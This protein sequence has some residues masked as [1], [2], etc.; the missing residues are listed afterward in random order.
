MNNFLNFQVEN[1]DI[2]ERGSLRDIVNTEN[3][4]FAAEDE[5]PNDGEL[6]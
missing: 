6:F 1:F 3:E 5:S 2:E 4:N